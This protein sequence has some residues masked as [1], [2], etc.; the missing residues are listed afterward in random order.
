[1]GSIFKKPINDLI[2]YQLNFHRNDLS[3]D[4]LGKLVSDFN[5]EFSFWSLLVRKYISNDQRGQYELYIVHDITPYSCPQQIILSDDE[6]MKMETFVKAY[7]I[8]V[9]SFNKYDKTKN[10]IQRFP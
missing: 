7:E 10:F 4:E 8:A 9:R 3:G 6:L 2:V 5:K 1:M